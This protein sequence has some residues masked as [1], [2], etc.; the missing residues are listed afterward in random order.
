MALPERTDFKV[1]LTIEKS[2]VEYDVMQSSEDITRPLSFARS[3]LA[4]ETLHITSVDAP[5]SFPLNQLGK[6]PLSLFWKH[7]PRTLGRSRDVNIIIPENV[8]L[9]VIQDY[10]CQKNCDYFSIQSE[11]STSFLDFWKRIGYS[12]IFSSGTLRL[13]YRY[14]KILC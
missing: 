6:D 1:F 11:S 14:D 13:R 12:L 9:L 5:S 7:F 4:I 10:R 8:Y 2:A 3:I